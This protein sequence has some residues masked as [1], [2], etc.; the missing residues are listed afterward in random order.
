MA[1]TMTALPCC[2]HAG[3]VIQVF[4]LTTS[5]WAHEQEASDMGDGSSQESGQESKE[6]E[7]GQASEEED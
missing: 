4:V 3:L 2:K 6:E 1:S 5:S 7:S